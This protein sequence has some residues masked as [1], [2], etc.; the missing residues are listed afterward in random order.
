MHCLYWLIFYLKTV[1]TST[2]ERSLR[3]GA[4]EKESQMGHS[5]SLSAMSLH[6][7]P[8]L[9]EGTNRELNFTT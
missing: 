7:S 2:I 4:Q 5:D 1:L 8:L 9:Q 3:E 6:V